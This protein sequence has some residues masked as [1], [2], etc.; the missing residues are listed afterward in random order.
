LQW[1]G[2]GTSLVKPLIRLHP[3]LHFWH[4]NRPI[5]QKDDK[6][7][8]TH[9]P[10]DRV[11]KANEPERDGRRPKFLRLQGSDLHVIESRHEIRGDLSRF[12]FR[13]GIGRILFASIKDVFQRAAVLGRAS[14]PNSSTDIVGTASKRLIRIVAR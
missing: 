6:K 2:Y 14:I 11:G 4:D 10:L 12:L 3:L 5:G 8:L 9:R 7:H 13:Y 1:G